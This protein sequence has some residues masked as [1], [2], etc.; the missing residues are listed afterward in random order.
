MNNIEEWKGGIL[1]RPETVNDLIHIAYKCNEHNAKGCSFDMDVDP[2]R[3]IMMHVEFGFEIVK[4]ESED[5]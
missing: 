3:E 1:L 4:M 2:D 5:K